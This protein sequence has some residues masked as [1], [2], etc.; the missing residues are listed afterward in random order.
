[1]ANTAMF[2]KI[3]DQI[4]NHP[5]GFNMLS[6]ESYDGCGTT[7][8]VAGWAIYLRAEELGYGMTD[9]YLSDVVTQLCQNG[10]VSDT[11]FEVAGA[12]ILGIDPDGDTA[13]FH[14]DN[15]EAADIV[16]AFAEGR[17]NDAFGLIDGVM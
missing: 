14:C 5:E 3:H 9:D 17:D 7:R 12:E 8:C 13:L 6:W 10:V 4:S 16:K 1:M 2:R 15:N 11:E